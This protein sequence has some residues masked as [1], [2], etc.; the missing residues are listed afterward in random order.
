MIKMIQTNIM[1][2]K[3]VKSSSSDQGWR[4]E[5]LEGSIDSFSATLFGL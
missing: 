4:F 1:P 2:R 5:V 3:W